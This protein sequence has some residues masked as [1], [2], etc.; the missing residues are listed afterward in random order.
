MVLPAHDESGGDGVRGALR[1]LWLFD[2]CMFA[3]AW[4]MWR[5]GWLVK[6]YKI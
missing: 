5:R 6:V 2:A 4:G 1:H 3:P